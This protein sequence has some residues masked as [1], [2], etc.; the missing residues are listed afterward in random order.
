MEKKKLGEYNDFC[1]QSD[2]LFSWLLADVFKNFWNICLEIYD[3]DPANFLS[4]PQLAWQATLS[5]YLSICKTNNRY[6]KD[7]DKDK[8]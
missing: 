7:Y 4:A 5:V 6:M 1:V 3:L 2:T 8:E